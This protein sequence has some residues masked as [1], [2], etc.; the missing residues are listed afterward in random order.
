MS[1]PETLSHSFT[2]IHTALAIDMAIQKHIHMDTW[3][4]AHNLSIGY[5][6]YPFSIKCKIAEE[7]PLGLDSFMTTRIEELIIII[8]FCLLFPREMKR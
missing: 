6:N 2:H 3:I 4:L 7:I 8:Y 1:V 5:A